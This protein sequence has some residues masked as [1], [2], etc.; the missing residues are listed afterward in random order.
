MAELCHVCDLFRVALFG[1]TSAT[2]VWFLSRLCMCR[3]GGPTHTLPKARV[4]KGNETPAV[5]FSWPGVAVAA[6]C[7]TTSEPCVLEGERAGGPG[8]TPNA[9]RGRDM[10]LHALG[11]RFSCVSLP[12]ASFIIDNCVRYI[13]PKF[14]PTDSQPRC[15]ARLTVETRITWTMPSGTTCQGPWQTPLQLWV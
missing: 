9:L 11:A 6:V 7:K 10:G 14:V 13:S 12:F 1:E 3:L 15:Q 4:T 8:A 5:F 2:R